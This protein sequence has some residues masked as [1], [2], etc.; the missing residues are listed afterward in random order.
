MKN[1]IYLL[2]TGNFAN[3]VKENT[4]NILNTIK[5]NKAMSCLAAS[6]ASSGVA[7]IALHLDHDKTAAAALVLSAL[8]YYKAIDLEHKRNINNIDALRESI[9]NRT[10]ALREELHSH[11]TIA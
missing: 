7:C 1:R 10:D 6:Y 8:A 5:N 3:I 9:R 11:G 2:F 4:M